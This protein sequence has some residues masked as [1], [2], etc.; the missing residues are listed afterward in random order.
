[1][2]PMNRSGFKRMA[3]I[4]L[5]FFLI[6]GLSLSCKGGNSSN[7]GDGDVEVAQEVDGE[8][9]GDQDPV[10]SDPAT[11]GDLIEEGDTDSLT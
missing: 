10:D 8:Q 5:I 7:E 3:L 6:G 9:T 2:R 4:L 1:M 11:E